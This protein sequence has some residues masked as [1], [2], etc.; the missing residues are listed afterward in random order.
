[1]LASTSTNRIHTPP[2]QT[3]PLYPGSVVLLLHNHTHNVVPSQQVV[4]S[5]STSQVAPAHGR[6][7]ALDLSAKPAPHGPNVSHVAAAGE[8]GGGGGGVEIRI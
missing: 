5:V 7:A 4:L 8:R 6:V 2:S 3:T 1:M